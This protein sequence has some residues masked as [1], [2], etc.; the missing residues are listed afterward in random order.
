MPNLT[1]LSKCVAVWPA[2]SGSRLEIPRESQYAH[3]HR[4]THL[5]I[6]GADRIQTPIELCQHSHAHPEGIRGLWQLW[7][8]CLCLQLLCH[9]HRLQVAL[10]LVVLGRL[11]LLAV[12]HILNL[13]HCQ[14]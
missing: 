9:C 10:S 14:S 12:T 1:A 13:R 8:C 3:R 2:C 5:Q 7:Q 11:R 6:S 4:V